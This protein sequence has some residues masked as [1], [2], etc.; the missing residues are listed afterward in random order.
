MRKYNNAVGIASLVAVVS[1]WFGPLSARSAMAEADIGHGYAVARQCYVANVFASDEF[2]R[3][4]DQAKAALYM[5]QAKR[6]FAFAKYQGRALGLSEKA[7]G[8]DLDA[9]EA[10]ET[11]PMLSEPGYFAKMVAVCKAAGFM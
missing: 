8:D 1:L 7:I 3:R 6:A 2:E 9:T 5:S 4:G 11:K 10:S